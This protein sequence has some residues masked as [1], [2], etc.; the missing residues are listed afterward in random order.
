MAACTPAKIVCPGTQEVET[1]DFWLASERRVSAVCKVRAL[2]CKTLLKYFDL[3][4]P[5]P[6]AERAFL[7]VGEA[8]ALSCTRVLAKVGRNAAPGGDF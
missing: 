6:A 4:T 3:V 7:L 5:E 2:R 8:G 1:R